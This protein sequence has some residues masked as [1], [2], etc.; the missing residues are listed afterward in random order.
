MEN[1]M[2]N[3]D[4]HSLDLYNQ[5]LGKV[6][7]SVW[8]NSGL[9][10]L[11]LADNRLTTIAEEIGNLATL[12]MLDLGHNKLASLPELL[13]ETDCRTGCHIQG[14]HPTEMRNPDLVCGQG[15]Q[16]VGNSLPFVTEQPGHRLP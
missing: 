16:L 2:E 5:G 9:E 8:Q 11:N 12:E 1:P 14:L 15:H 3:E 6:P 4:L 13:K 7:K 10:T